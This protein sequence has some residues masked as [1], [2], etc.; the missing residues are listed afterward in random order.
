M[1]YRNPMRKSRLA[2]SDILSD[3]D[4]IFLQHG[5]IHNDISGWLCKKRQGCA[6]FVTTAKTERESLIGGNYHYSEDEVGLTGMP[7]FDR[8]EDNSEKLITILPTW[9]RYLTKNQNVTTGI[10]ELKNDFYNTEYA[11]F[12]RTLMNSER[13]RSA[14]EE[15]GYTIQFKIHPSFLTHESQFGFDEKVKIVGNDV[16]YKE[17]YSKSSLII[18]DFSSGIYDFIYLRK[19]IIYCQFDRDDFFKNH[20]TEQVQLDYEKDGYGEIVTKIDE[21]IDTIIDY[22]KNDC[23]LKDKYRERIDAFFTYND[24]GN[25]QRIYEKI[26]NL[27]KK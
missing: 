22:M 14:A 20:M 19:P 25:S 7:R 2:Y 1:V 5:V 8:L 24:R 11:T 9:R 27:K 13:L 26:V 23:K 3:V 17:I 10:W 6:G 18:T 4:F 15:Y 21:T 16:P 12:Y